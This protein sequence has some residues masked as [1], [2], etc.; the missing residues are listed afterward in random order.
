MSAFYIVAY[1]SLSIPAV[2]AGGVDTPLGLKL[3][4]EIFGSHRRRGRTGRSSPSVASTAQA[5]LRRRPEPS[6]PARP[7]DAGVCVR[8]PRGL[9][10]SWR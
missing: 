4:F 6:S 1:T 8:R 7:R 3:T 2:L 5:Q 10:L 9:D